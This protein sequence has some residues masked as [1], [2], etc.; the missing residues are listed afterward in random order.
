MRLP[1]LPVPAEV[2]VLKSDRGGSSPV[3][4]EPTVATLGPAVACWRHRRRLHYLCDS[5][6]QSFPALEMR[7]RH[8]SGRAESLK[9]GWLSDRYQRVSIS[10]AVAFTY[11]SVSLTIEQAPSTLTAVACLQRVDLQYS[12]P[13]VAFLA[14]MQPP[15]RCHS[16][17]N[18]GGRRETKWSTL[19]P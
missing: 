13:K 19:T 12:P 17:A 4:T 8:L 14:H 2:I 11:D 6:S 18:P 7:C 3:N 10:K 9:M 15:G 16:R 1:H 5:N